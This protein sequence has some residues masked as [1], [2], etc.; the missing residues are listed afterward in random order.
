M[1]ELTEYRKQ[2]VDRLEEAA[3]EFQTA[4]LA[5]KNSFAPIEEGGW[6]VHQLAV[7][8][9]DVDRLVYGLRAR[10][11]LAEDNP[12]FPNF[13]GTTHMAEKYDRKEPLSDVLDGFSKSVGEQVELLRGMPVEAWS[14]LSRHATQGNG[15]T[16]QMWVERGVEHLEEHL[17]TIKRGGEQ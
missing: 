1:N 4:A 13:D 3:K 5:V 9:R 7:H 17:A 15:L 16:L 8:A 14:R 10:R 6:N 2:L 11:T 12:E